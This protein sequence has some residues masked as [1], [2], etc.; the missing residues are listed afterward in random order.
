M[1][2]ELR[3]ELWAGGGEQEMGQ[4]KADSR[5]TNERQPRESPR[6]RGIKGGS[7]TL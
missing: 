5:D 2:L 4:E 7:R 1:G 3:R 6:E